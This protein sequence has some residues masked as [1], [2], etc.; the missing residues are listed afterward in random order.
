MNENPNLYFQDNF[1][2]VGIES[3]RELNKQT[4]SDGITRFLNGLNDFIFGVFVDTKKESEFEVLHV[5]Y[6]QYKMDFECIILPLPVNYENSNEAVLVF[7]SQ[8]IK[9]NPEKD[10]FEVFNT[11]QHHRESALETLGYF[12]FNPE[13]VQN[14]TLIAVGQSLIPVLKIDRIDFFKKQ[15]A[16]AKSYENV[17]KDIEN[18][19]YLMVDNTNGL[20]KIGRSKNPKYREGTLQS[21]EPETV[22]IVNWRAPKQTEKELHSKFASKRIRG[23]WFRLTISDLDEIKKYMNSLDEI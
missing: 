6:A 16:D 20:I 5:F 8:I 4:P 12:T 17:F 23:E 1:Y 15:F 11:L 10:V 7:A 13:T 3:L 22:M 18:Y 21:K 2:K 14:G 9:I 19:I